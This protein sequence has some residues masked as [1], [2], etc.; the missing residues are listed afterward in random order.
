MMRPRWLERASGGRSKGRPGHPVDGAQGPRAGGQAGRRSSPGTG[1]H[2]VR[3]GAGAQRGRRGDRGRRA[4]Q[5]EQTL[6]IGNTEIGLLSSVAL[7]VGAVF[8][9]PIGL[10]VDRFKRMPLLSLT[11]VLWSVASLLSAFAGSR[12]GRVSSSRL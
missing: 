4:P 7:L 2:A 11:I 10:Y 12:A 3:H 6:Q 8:T 9:I 5:L 1:D